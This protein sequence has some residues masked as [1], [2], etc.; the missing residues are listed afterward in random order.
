MLLIKAIDNDRQL[1]EVLM[2]KSWHHHHYLLNT[3]ALEGAGR[4]EV[5]HRSTSSPY[6]LADGLTCEVLVRMYIG[7][8]SA[9]SKIAE[10]LG[11]LATG[12]GHVGG[13]CIAKLCQVWRG[14]L[15]SGDLEIGI[16]AAQAQ[17][18]FER[19]VSFGW[20]AWSH[21]ILG[22]LHRWRGQW[23]DASSSYRESVAS[24]TENMF[25]HASSSAL[26]LAQLESG[27]ASA[28][29]V[30]RQLP[31]AAQPEGD[32]LVGAWEQLL[33][34]VEGLAILRDHAAAAEL[35]LLVAH[36]LDPETVLSLN[37]RLWQMV[38]GI[39]AACG[40]HWDAAQEHYETAL[41]Q[42]HVLLH[43]IAQPEVRRWYAQMLL[44][45]NAAGDLEKARTLLGE[46]TELY[47]TIGMPKHLEMV[48]KMS[49]EL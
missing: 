17:V 10:E 47:R 3:E 30:I 33:N 4:A 27:D 35:Y 21:A 23:S 41:K 49:A 38:A 36:G 12:V 48:A 15:S 13:V 22:T 31:L 8:F 6:M 43:K 37:S 16:H 14:V 39:A 29:E 1:A 32:N 2:S 20:G 9:V 11:P 24:E 26:L 40:Q 45:R 7:D 19:Q 34:V 46:V 5:I 42:A 28:A 44:D 25:R 18:G